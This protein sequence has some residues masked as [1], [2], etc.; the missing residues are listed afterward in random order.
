M[1]VVDIEDR[2]E[3]SYF[4]RYGSLGGSYEVFFY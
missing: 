1:H 3:S 2:E 4:L